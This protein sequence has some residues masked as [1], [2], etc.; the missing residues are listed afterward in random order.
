[1]APPA[2]P[3]GSNPSAELL[4][5]VIDTVGCRYLSAGRAHGRVGLKLR[6]RQTATG[7]F[8]FNC[9]G[10]PAVDCDEIGNA[11]PHAQALQD[12]RLDRLTMAAVKNMEDENAGTTYGKMPNES[13]LHVVLWSSTAHVI[14]SDWPTQGK[15]ASVCAPY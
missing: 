10:V 3:P 13:A 9:V 14:A 5:C 6:R 12:C 4:E 11:S 7:R 15:Q 1:M 8:Q 2:P